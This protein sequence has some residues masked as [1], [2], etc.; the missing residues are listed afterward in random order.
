LRCN[1]APEIWAGGTL[2]ASLRIILAVG[3]TWTCG[4]LLLLLLLLLLLWLLLLLRSTRDSGGC[5]SRFLEEEKWID[6]FE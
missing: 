3:I 2:C 4:R 6:C 1:S 5:N